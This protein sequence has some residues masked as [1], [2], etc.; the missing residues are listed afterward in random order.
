MNVMHYRSIE[1]WL[2]IACNISLWWGGSFHRNREAKRLVRVLG[3]KILL[4]DIN[5][6]GNNIELQAIKEELIQEGKVVEW[7][8]ADAYLNML[9]PNGAQKAQYL[10]A[11]QQ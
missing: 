6:T 10:N 8:T 3:S 2:T 1:S 7:C 11:K 4:S 5:L 9:G